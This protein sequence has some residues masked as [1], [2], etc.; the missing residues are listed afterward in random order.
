MEVTKQ[1]KPSVKRATK[2]GGSASVQAVTRV[3]AEQASKRRRAGRPDCHMR[4][5][6]TGWGSEQ[7]MRP[8]TAPG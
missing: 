7:T 6:L 4:G 3:N 8:V 1:L 2:Y 5:R